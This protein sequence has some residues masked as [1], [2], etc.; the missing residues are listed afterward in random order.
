MPRKM[1]NNP[2]KSGIR[3]TFQPDKTKNS[4]T[5]YLFPSL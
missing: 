3:D 4:E 5:A 1:P 2:L